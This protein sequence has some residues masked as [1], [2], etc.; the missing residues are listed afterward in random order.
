MKTRNENNTNHE[1]TQKKK[2]SN[3][4]T[5]YQKRTHPQFICSVKKFKKKTI[6]KKTEKAIIRMLSKRFCFVWKRKKLLC[7]KLVVSFC[8]YD[9]NRI[10]PNNLSSSKTN[11]LKLV[12]NFENSSKLWLESHSIANKKDYLVNKINKNTNEA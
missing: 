12:K 5:F 11:F 4:R 2:Q 3:N 9:V 7:K 1:A 8:E 6:I 10:T